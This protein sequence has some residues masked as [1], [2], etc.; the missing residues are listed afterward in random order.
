MSNSDIITSQNSVTNTGVHL[1]HTCVVGE[2]ERILQIMHEGHRQRLKERFLKDGLDG[3][4]P[5]EVLELLLFYSIPRRDTNPTGHLLIDRFGSL[6]NVFSAPFAELVQ[7]DGVSENSATLI[8]LMPALCRYYQ[9]DLNCKRE[10]LN[11][12]GRAVK[13]ISSQLIG[14]DTEEV[15]L[16]CLDSKRTLIACEHVFSGS[17]NSAQISV[18]RIVELCLRHNATGVILAHNHPGGL[19]L[20]SQ[21]D[22]VTTGKIENALE[23]IGVELLDH[24]IYADGDCVSLADSGF[25]HS[26]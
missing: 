19:A 1:L 23:V 3:F 7:V 18:R 24:I 12:S 21:E 2:E 4:Q 5:H 11:S 20:P 26:I 25:I 14:Y 10:Q 13:Y 16:L 8:K 9:T 6:S 17:V 15:L 22:L